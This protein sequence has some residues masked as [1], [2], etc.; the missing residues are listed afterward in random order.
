[1]VV[2]GS[3]RAAFVSRIGLVM[4][5]AVVSIALAAQFDRARSLPQ[6]SVD[7]GVGFLGGLAMAVCLGGSGADLRWT[8]FAFASGWV[9][10]SSAGLAAHRNQ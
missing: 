6:R 10:L 3:F 2:S 8:L 9:G 7:I 1:M 5:A 4:G